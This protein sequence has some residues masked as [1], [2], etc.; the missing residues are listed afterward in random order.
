MKTTNT[1]TTLTTRRAIAKAFNVSVESVS[2]WA[3]KDGFPGGEAGPWNHVAIAAWL[4]DRDS[5]VSRRHA[6]ADPDD[7]I[8]FDLL[9]P[10]PT[11]RMKLLYVGVKFGEML[12]DRRDDFNRLTQA[13]PPADMDHVRMCA[14]QYL[15]DLLDWEAGPDA[16]VAKRV[17]SAL[18]LT[19]KRAR[20][21]ERGLELHPNDDDAYDASGN[22][23]PP[24]IVIE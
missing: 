19:A 11:L 18:G 10:R 15:C 21:F 6:A 5:P 13:I 17:C 24:E 1:S 8:T 20:Y 3:L 2:R 16:D 23:I 12:F 22:L 7:E 9:A 4:A 14:L